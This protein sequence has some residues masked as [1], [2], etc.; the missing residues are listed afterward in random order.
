MD[1]PSSPLPRR[2]FL[3]LT[4][5]AL[6]LAATSG[7]ATAG[8][9]R[10]TGAGLLSAGAATDRTWTPERF[11]PWIELDR[12]AWTQN[13]REAAR[14]ASGRPI[15][16]VVKNNAYGLGDRAVGPLLAGMP[17]VGGIAS[18]RVEEALAMREEGVTKPIVVMAEGS[19]DEIEEMARHDI[20][21]SVWLDDAP[22]RLRSVSRRLGRPVPVQLF[23]DTG[24]NRE[25]M[26][27][28][29][30]RRWIEELV[31][32]E[33]VDVNG[34]YTMFIHDLDFNREQLARFEE[35]LAWARGK[36]L[37]LGTLHASPSF[38]LFNLPEAHYDMVRPGNAL[39]GNHLSGG[40]GAGEMADLRP[41][42][43]MNARVVRVERLEPGDGAGFR[44][45]FT[46][47][48]AT[49]VALLPVGRT[50]GYPSEA[51]GTCEVLINGRLYPVAGGVNSAHTILDIGPEKTVEVGDVAT[52]IGPDHPSVLPHTV[53]ERT[54]RGFLGIIQFMN[55]RLPR[56]VV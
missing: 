40:E 3:H 14:L 21:P 49:W 27:Y 20:L 46:A 34:T 42:F 44:H 2:R 36:N 4:G 35:L 41:V 45:T 53:A 19:E 1:R 22:A 48:R 37:P 10:S 51:N 43:R 54:G 24:M 38:E 7:C 15:L 6:G 39:F 25:G 52:L 18:V 17:E 56:R 47:D 50:D 11:D 9:T 28:T 32:S 55:P 12:A 23:I 33:Y 13:V 16:A 29:R 8:R 5:A 31:Q 26:P 30:A